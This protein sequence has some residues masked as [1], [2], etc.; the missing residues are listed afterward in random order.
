MEWEELIKRFEV[1]AEFFAR[2]FRYMPYKLSKRYG[3]L[4]VIPMVLETKER[5]QFKVKIVLGAVSSIVRVREAKEP[6]RSSTSAEIYLASPKSLGGYKFP[7]SYME[8][9]HHAQIMLRGYYPKRYIDLD[10]NLVQNALDRAYHD[11]RHEIKEY[12]ERANREASKEQRE[13]WRLIMIEHHCCKGLSKVVEL[14][15]KSR[16][17]IGSSQTIRNI[18]KCAEKARKFRPTYN[19]EE[20]LT[21][22][23]PSE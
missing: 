19:S 6:N 15:H 5:K 18:R 3:G 10:L 2:Q 1:L 16:G 21:I 7:N 4:V 22:L 13:L 8:F 9:V 14:C 11:L 12:F 20:G 23:L 17:K